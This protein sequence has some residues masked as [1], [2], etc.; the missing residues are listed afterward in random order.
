L[1]TRAAAIVADFIVL[2]VTWYKT[3]GIVREAHLLGIRMPIG[4]ILFRDGE[5][6]SANDQLKL[7][8]NDVAF[9]IVP[10][11]RVGSLFFL[12]VQQNSSLCGLSLIM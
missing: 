2:A 6:S 4:E 11:E 7:G 10:T 12:W 8:A 9:A 1:G 5:L 3:I